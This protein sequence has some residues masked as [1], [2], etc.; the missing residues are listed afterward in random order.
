[1]DGGL[2][3]TPFQDQF[4]IMKSLKLVGFMATLRFPGYVTLLE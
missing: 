3:S 4:H 1:M 2:N